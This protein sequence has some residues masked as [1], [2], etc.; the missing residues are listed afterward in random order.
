M[1]ST[2]AVGPTP[3]KGMEAAAMQK[4]GSVVKQLT[5]LLSM[6]GATSEIGK[7]VMPVIS[8]LA[9]H[10]PPGA[11]TPASEANNIQNMALKNAQNQQMLQ[12][13]KPGAQGGQAPP[14]M[15]PMAA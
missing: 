12:S 13:M 5:E 8:K 3:N 11:V 10:V 2:S 7:D 1:G 6:V 4:L 9:K 15:P 14:Q